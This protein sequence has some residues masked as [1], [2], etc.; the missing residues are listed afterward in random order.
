MSGLISLWDG[1]PH[2][3]DMVSREASTRL[4]LVRGYDYRLLR[5]RCPSIC[6][7]ME[8]QMAYRT[9]LLHELLIGDASM[10]LDVRLA[11]VLHMLAIL[12]G[13]NRPMASSRC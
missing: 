1:Q 7:A 13:R 11:R 12:S 2:A 6:R 8:V 4:L 10:P 9:R 5:D 3:T